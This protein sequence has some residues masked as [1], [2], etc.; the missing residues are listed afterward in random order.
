MLS[1]KA[2][3]FLI[4]LLLASFS[5]ALSQDFEV[6][7]VLVS[8]DANPGENQNQTI[9]VRNHSNEKHKFG[10]SLAD[11][12]ISNEGAKA[13]VEAGSTG[14]SLADWITVNP[15]LLSLTPM[16]LHRLN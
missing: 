4:N 6:A 13:A 7:P 12:T 14:R 8:F 15:S 11:Y 5:F 1:T 3:I 9:T 2:R 16:S 10:L